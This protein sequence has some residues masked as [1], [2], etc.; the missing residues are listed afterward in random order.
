MPFISH[1]A[2]AKVEHTL[3][4]GHEL[5]RRAK[6]KATEKANQVK[7]AAEIVFGGLAVGYARGKMED[8]NGQWLIPGT[9]LDI[10]LVAGAGLIGAALFDV[11]GDYDD[12]AV[13]VGAG[14]LA[15]YGGQ[16]G[17][18]F[19]KSGSLQWPLIAG[20]SAP[21]IGRGG[22][23]IVG[24]DDLATALSRLNAR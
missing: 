18:N 23:P 16:V 22:V 21:I 12:D 4:R 13:N 5:A 24:A 9:T 6:A 19:A 1:N 10:E 3:N 15:H 11:L 14:M 2:L 20:G 8:A 17:R 7:D